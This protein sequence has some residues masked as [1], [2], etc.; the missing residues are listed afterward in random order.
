MG[1]Q[2]FT[3]LP[4]GGPRR[5]LAGALGW[6]EKPMLALRVVDQNV[7]PRTQS[8]SPTVAASIRRGCHNSSNYSGART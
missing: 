4:I 5:T 2:Q 3:S 6:N 1:H 8:T 7:P